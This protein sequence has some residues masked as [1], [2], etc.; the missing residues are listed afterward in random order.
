MSK[1]SSLYHRIP[2]KIRSYFPCIVTVF[3]LIFI[4]AGAILFQNLEGEN[5]SLEDRMFRRFTRELFCQEA[6]SNTVNLHY[7]LKNP[8]DYGIDYAPVT[9]GNIESDKETVLATVE[10]LEKKL[11]NYSKEKLSVENRL[12]YE[13]LEYYTDIVKGDAEYLL[14]DEP[15]GLVS[16][17]Q[18]QLPVVLSEYALDTREDVETYLELMKTTTDYFEQIAVFER[19]KSEAGLFMSDEAAEQVIEQ[20]N[21]FIN[22]KESNYLI[23]S[24]VERIQ[25]IKDMTDKEKSDYIQENALILETYILPAYQKLISEIEK[26]KGTGKNERGLCYLP[27]GKDYYEQEVQAMVGSDRTI[28]E[29]KLMT[30]A[31]ILDDL[32]A[33]EQVLGIERSESGENPGTDETSAAAE[34]SAGISLSGKVLVGEVSIDAAVSCEEMMAEENPVTIL[35][36]LKEKISGAFPELSD[37]TVQ[38]KYVPEAME[39]HL[40]PAFYMIPAIDDY[41][42]NVIYVNQAYMGNTLTLFTTLAHEGYPGHLY[43]TVYFSE[44]NPDPVRMSFGFGGYVEGWATYAEM[45]SYYLAPLTKQ[46]A[47]LLQKNNSI[48][49][50]LYSLAD[51]GIHYEGWSLLDT[52]AFFSNYGITQTVKIEE[53]YDLIIGSPGNYLKYYIGYLEFLELKKDWMKEKGEDFSQKEF[54]EAVLSVGPAPFELVQKYAEL[55]AEEKTEK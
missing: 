40:S 42:Q 22:M 4:P 16:G 21:A 44:T 25:Q 49:L 12:T 30:Q 28:K 1:F 45:C 47:T 54:H 24:F 34:V 29:M 35:Q 38:V 53:I 31:Q 13:I 17:V 26:L 55:L 39:E 15:L 11:D 2:D 6:A 52:I 19:K 50:G 23:S 7:T 8:E 32:E 37:T 18:T 5:E 41:E 43:Q 46:Q 14:Y 36:D 33:M 20:C 48:L 9:F 10:N 51:I 3:L 27:E